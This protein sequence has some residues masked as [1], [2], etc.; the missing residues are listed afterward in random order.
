M[1]QDINNTS[2]IVTVVGEDAVTLV[3]N[4]A[5]QCSKNIFL[6]GELGKRQR[7][8]GA[9]VRTSYFDSCLISIPY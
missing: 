1:S 7:Q 8:K 2:R 5:V 4:T 3:I 6:V 9:T